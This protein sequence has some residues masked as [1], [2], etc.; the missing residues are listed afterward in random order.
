M[1]HIFD[2]E[3]AKKH[4]FPAAVIYENICH[5]VRV[6]KAN[7]NNLH[8]G[9]FWTF[10][11]VKAFGEIFDYL[12][13]W[14]IRSALE[15]LVDAGLI[16]KGQFNNRGYD[17]TAWYTSNDA[18]SI[19]NIDLM[20]AANAFDE[21][22]KWN[23]G[24]PQKDLMGSANAFDADSEPIP[25]IKPDSKPDINTHT[26]RADIPIPDTTPAP[27]VNVSRFT[28]PLKQYSEHVSKV[29]P[30]AMD[31]RLRRAVEHN[32]PET[33]E[34]AILAIV[35]ASKDSQYPKDKLPGSLSALLADA[36]RVTWWA[37]L[38]KPAELPEYLSDPE[39]LARAV[40]FKRD[41]NQKLTPMEED[42]CRRLA[43][44]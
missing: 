7:G 34:N 36:E 41:N 43:I 31:Y 1:K 25:D 28:E 3:I 13:P 22:H 24:E 23:C 33:V 19:A 9:R 39:K 17:R 35:E 29:D 2:T 14:Q 26:P 12:T 6:N 21:G 8:D 32:S 16:L 5:W 30:I 18:N 4:G 44:A 27:Q 42:A 20:P 10:N 40:K 38:Y 37:R 15:I 11:S